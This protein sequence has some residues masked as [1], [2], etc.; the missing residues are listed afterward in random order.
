MTDNMNY[1]MINTLKDRIIKLQK[2]KS[3]VSK[4]FEIRDKDYGFIGLVFLKYVLENN[5]GLQMG[6]NDYIYYRQ[7]LNFIEGRG[8]KIDQKLIDDLSK[9]GVFKNFHSLPNFDLFFDLIGREIVGEY[10]DLFNAVN[11]LNLLENDIDDHSVG[12]WLASYFCSDENLD[13]NESVN[14][15]EFRQNTNAVKLIKGLIGQIG[16]YDSVLNLSSAIG[17]P[18]V[19]I[20]GDNPVKR[21]DTLSWHPYN[22]FVDE[23]NMML[24]IFANVQ[25]D[26][27]RFNNI[28]RHFSRRLFIEEDDCKYN[29]IFSD[30]SIVDLFRKQLIQHGADYLKPD[31]LAIITGYS[32]FQNP[33]SNDIFSDVYA[34]IPEDE[35]EYAFHTSYSYEQILD[36]IENK[37]AK[38]GI[39]VL[40]CFTGMLQTVKYTEFR[41]KLLKLGLK[42]VISLPVCGAN[43]TI[44]LSVLV[45]QNGWNGG[46]MF[47]DALN[48]KFTDK[49]VRNSSNRNAKINDDGIDYLIKVVNEQ[50]DELGISA[51]IDKRQIDNGSCILQPAMYCDFGKIA[52]KG[53]NVAEI[54][55]EIDE[56]ANQIQNILQNKNG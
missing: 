51:T 21:F 20:M 18:E 17:Q 1:E 4:V 34:N 31:N 56:I 44:R 8:T 36:K 49:F 5:V 41:R 55:K 22:G 11:E 35:V 6:D 27:Q 23:L 39:A 29:K 47:V 46:I 40:T 33:V 16:R 53:R 50:K 19:I 2:L 52:K 43:T 30:L 9:S 12:K 7:M 10:Q 28:Y 45:I 37:L 26:V 32:N 38:N 14:R 13:S 3:A 24:R 42:A 48:K 25:A 15:H 54:D